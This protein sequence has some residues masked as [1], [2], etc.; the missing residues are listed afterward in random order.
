MRSLGGQSEKLPRNW[1]EQFLRP[2]TAQPLRI[3][4]RLIVSNVG[5]AS[6]PSHI[7]FIPAGAAFGTGEHATTAMSLRLL[8]RVTRRLTNGWRMLDAGT[9][10]GILALAGKRFGAGEVFAIDNDPMAIST[11]KRNAHGNGIKGIKFIAGDLTKRIGGKYEIITANLY[12]E[13]LVSLLPRFRS[14]LSAQGRLIISGVL[15]DQEP[16]L[17]RALHVNRFQI[18]ESRRRGKWIALLAAPSA[19]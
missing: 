17:K 19:S 10:S 3:G 5:G 12:S 9:G 6:V 4:T 14:G 16:R 11:A 8:E 2:K 7:L 1:L 15:C 13:L 18:H